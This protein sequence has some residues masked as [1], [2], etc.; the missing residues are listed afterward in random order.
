MWLDDPWANALSA[1]N[2]RARLVALARE[3][4]EILRALESL[5]RDDEQPMRWQSATAAHAGADVAD[6]LRE[7]RRVHDLLWALAP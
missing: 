4:D 3:W 7:A 6:V 1:E 2:T 5:H